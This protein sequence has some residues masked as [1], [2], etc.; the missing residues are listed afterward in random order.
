MTCK[1]ILQ[2]P[3]A[4]LKDISTPVQS[5]DTELGELVQD[6]YD[7]LNVHM[8]VGLAAPQI[9]NFTRVVMV[10]CDIFGWKNE[11]PYEHDPDIW[12][13][14]NPKLE[15]MGEDVIWD[16]GCLSVPL[17]QGSIK[18]KSHVSVTYQDIEGKEHKVDASWPISGALQ[19][20]CD[21]LDG[22]VFLDRMGR[23]RAKTLKQKIH[24]AKVLKFRELKR[25][26]RKRP[27]PEKELIDTRLQHGPG[28][29]KKKKKNKKKRP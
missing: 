25:K 15:L 12:V 11:D 16:E 13:L 23:V 27:K 4:A 14:V 17:V 10:K 24:L 1:Q 29:R 9:A 20:E 3:D 28:K 5:F 6:M 7:T 19:H 2:W 26:A 18:R 21:H 22:L 8:G